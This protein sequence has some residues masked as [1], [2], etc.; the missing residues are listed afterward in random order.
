MRLRYKRLEKNIAYHV[1]KLA[2]D[3]KRYIDFQ[4][5]PDRDLIPHSI[6]GLLA[7]I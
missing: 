1:T 7:D 6:V 5:D 3:T 4:P 2:K